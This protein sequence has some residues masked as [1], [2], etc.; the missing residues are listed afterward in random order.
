MKK[1]LVIL[2]VAFSIYSFA[3]E[4]DTIPVQSIYVNDVCLGDSTYKL[5]DVFGIPTKTIKGLVDDA[6][7]NTNPSLNLYY[8]GDN[9]FSEPYNIIQKRVGGFFLIDK[10]PKIFLEIKLE[11]DGI[12]FRI[13]DTLDIKSINCAFPK[14]SKAKEFNNTSKYKT[15]ILI[16][17]FN[18]SFNNYP[19]E[20]I[21][22]L[23]IYFE[24]SILY[25]IA[26]NY[27]TE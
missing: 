23:T 24:D 18:E 6:I 26:T 5:Y 3:Q 2:G 10:N 4:Y 25:N 21:Q 15:L 7:E 19:Y 20:L 8:F 16:P 1:I 12:Q 22:S 13:G 14:S 9:Y 17:R 11:Y 27:Y